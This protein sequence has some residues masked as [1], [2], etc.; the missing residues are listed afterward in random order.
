MDAKM[1]ADRWER[2]GRAR[3]LEDQQ[4]TRQVA[5]DVKVRSSECFFNFD[6]PLEAAVFSVLVE[7]VKRM[8][9]GIQQG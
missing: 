7:I 5:T 3:R 2:P 9:D 1:F 4:Y 6:D 8:D